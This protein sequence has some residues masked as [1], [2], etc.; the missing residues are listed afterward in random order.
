MEVINNITNILDE[1]YKNMEF[2][3]KIDIN[4]KYKKSSKKQ[5]VVSYKHGIIANKDLYTGEISKIG[6]CYK[7]DGT[8][9]YEESVIEVDISSYKKANIQDIDCYGKFYYLKDGTRPF[10]D[11]N[12]NKIEKRR[13]FE[14]LMDNIEIEF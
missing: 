7:D 12:G 11:E 3:G 13:M 1:S 10:V 5:I 2:F 4:L 9:V 6:K 8:I 14:F